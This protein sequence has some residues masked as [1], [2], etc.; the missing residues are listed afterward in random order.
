MATESILGGITQEETLVD[1]RDAILFLAKAIK[2]PSYING[3]G[4]MKIDFASSTGSVAVTLTSTAIT[5][6]SGAIGTTMG[7]GDTDQTFVAH[8][9]IRD[10]YRQFINK[11]IT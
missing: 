9:I 4:Q 3:I 1:L 10:N 2:K 11:I 5:G 8:N 7:A 6:N